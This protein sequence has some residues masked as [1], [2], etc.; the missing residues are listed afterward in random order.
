MTKDRPGDEYLAGGPTKSLIRIGLMSGE[1]YLVDSQTGKRLEAETND[2]S[3]KTDNI[4]VVLD[5]CK[6]LATGDRAKTHG[7]F[8]DGMNATGDIQL[9]L[10][11]LDRWDD[12]GSIRK[13]CLRMVVVKLVRMCNGAHNRDDYLDAINYLAQAAD[14]DT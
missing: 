14:S 8:A 1:E 11:S 13:A 4:A 12:L 9:V 6:T 2:A 3:P 7:N 5:E 10:E